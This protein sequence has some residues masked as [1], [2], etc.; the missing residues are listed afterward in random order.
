MADTAHTLYCSFAIVLLA[1]HVVMSL[2]LYRMF[3]GSTKV[4]VTLA[5]LCAVDFGLQ[6]FA[7]IYV[8]R[9]LQPHLDRMWC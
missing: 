1:A 5:A 4:L 9:E 6:L 3:N 2:R 7:Y 8:K